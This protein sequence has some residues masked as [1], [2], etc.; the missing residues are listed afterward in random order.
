MLQG[1]GF[2]RHRSLGESQHPQT[3]QGHIL[4]VALNL[5]VVKGNHLPI[6]AQRRR[7]P[8]QDDLG[9]AF[10]VNLSL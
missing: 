1:C 10:D 8:F 2:R 3:S 5:C 7:A 4:D 9:G 6:R